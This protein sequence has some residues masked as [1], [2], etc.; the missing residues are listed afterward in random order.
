MTSDPGTS[1]PGTSDSARTSDWARK[2]RLD[3][4]FGDDLPEQIVE[5]GE[6][7][8]SGRGRDWYDQNRPPHYE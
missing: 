6:N 5:P 4:V 1:D 7:T 3:A 2:R 8:G